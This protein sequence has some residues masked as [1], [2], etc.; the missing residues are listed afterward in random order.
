MLQAFDAMVFG[1]KDKPKS[2]PFKS[3][4]V[5]FRAFSWKINR[6]YKEVKG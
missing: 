4:L 1:A 5:Y 2:T 3:H 6:E